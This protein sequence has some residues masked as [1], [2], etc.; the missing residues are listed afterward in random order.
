MWPFKKKINPGTKKVL[1]FFKVEKFES[2]TVMLG[3]FADKDFS[4]WLQ[5]IH[6]IIQ[7]AIK[8]KTI[9][10]RIIE[11][12]ITLQMHIGGQRVDITIM[13]DGCKSPHELLQELKTQKEND[14][15]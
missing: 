4:A 2:E 6:D 5:W 1:D 11:N 12:Y 3:D 8:T 9:D 13:K 14:G 15:V 10:G 7:K